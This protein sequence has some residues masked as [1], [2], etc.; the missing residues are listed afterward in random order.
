MTDCKISYNLLIYVYKTSL[1]VNNA[2]VIVFKDRSFEC[3]FQN[4][5]TKSFEI[6]SKE[7]VSMFNNTQKSHFRQNQEQKSQIGNF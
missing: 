1:S 7:L 2:Y 6:L 5:R 4:E 3:C